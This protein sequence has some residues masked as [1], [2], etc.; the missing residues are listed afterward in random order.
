M[1]LLN[2]SNCISV[3]K[4]QKDQYVD[5]Y[6]NHVVRR[7]VVVFSSSRTA[8]MIYKMQ[9]ARQKRVHFE[10]SDAKQPTKTNTNYASSDRLPRKTTQQNN[11]PQQIDCILFKSLS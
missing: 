9:Y 1:N 8:L 11:K 6:S 7:M 3:V 10:Q 5:W 4:L 2:I